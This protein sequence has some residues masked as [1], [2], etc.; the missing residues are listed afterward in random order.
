MTINCIVG[1]GPDGKPQL[2]LDPSQVRGGGKPDKK[3]AIT[4]ILSKRAEFMQSLAAFGQDYPVEGATVVFE[5]AKVF[6]KFIM[7]L[8]AKAGPLTTDEADE[9]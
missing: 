1:T 5:T 3:Q 6:A 7:M 4:H 2:Q 8:E 9:D